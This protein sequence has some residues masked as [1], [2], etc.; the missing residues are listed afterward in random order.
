M[1][2]K[3]KTN[4]YDNR[5]ILVVGAV[6]LLLDLILACVYYFRY[7]LKDLETAGGIFGFGLVGVVA[8]LLLFHEKKAKIV[9][10][11]LISICGIFFMS[12]SVIL[13]L[14]SVRHYN[15]VKNLID[16][17]QYIYAEYD[18]IESSYY[19]VLKYTDDNSGE[20]YYFQT[21]SFR[22]KSDTPVKKGDAVKVYVDLSN[23]DLYLIS[24]KEKK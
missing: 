21:H 5:I 8:F 19:T 9:T 13:Y 18:H 12:T 20:S 16:N 10:N 6:I 23:P 24:Y 4:K 15:S 17:Q 2:T 3:E 11:V 14:N 22:W 1:R 7:S